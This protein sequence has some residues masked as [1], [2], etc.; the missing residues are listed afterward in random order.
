MADTISA[1]QAYDSIKTGIP[2]LVKATEELIRLGKVAPVS[3]SVLEG[4]NKDGWEK[5]LAKYPKIEVTEARAGGVRSGGVVVVATKLAGG[6]ERD[7]LVA[8]AKRLVEAQSSFIEL[9]KP[10]KQQYM[11]FFIRG[12]GT[13]RGK[14]EAA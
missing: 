3:K 4:K 7:P 6:N 10:H 9:L 5:F 8:A 2:S 1:K 14:K 13:P 11:K 12:T